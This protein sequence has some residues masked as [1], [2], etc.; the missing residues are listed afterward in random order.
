MGFGLPVVNWIEEFP[1]TNKPLSYQGGWGRKLNC[2]ESK[3][4]GPRLAA[5]IHDDEKRI[6]DERLRNVTE[7]R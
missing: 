3:I 2:L 1:N 6:P 4:L 5:A 7:A